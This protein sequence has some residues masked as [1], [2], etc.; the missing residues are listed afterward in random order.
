MKVFISWSGKHSQ[1]IAMTLRD[2]LPSVIQALDP[3]V[4]SA[5]IEKGESWFTSINE[6]LVGSN[7]MGIF[8][9]TAENLQAPWMA[10]EAGALAVHDRARV[11]TFL[12]GV[13]PDAI[14]PP[15]GLFQA[16]NSADKTDVFK[17]LESL[18]VRLNQPLS[19]VRLKKAFDSNWDA[20][21][22]DLSQIQD[23]SSKKTAQPDQ[24]V[25]LH[26]ILA[27]VRRIEK[28][29]NWRLG[30]DDQQSSSDGGFPKGPIG[31]RSPDPFGLHAN[32]FTSTSLRNSFGETDATVERAMEILR[33]KDQ[34]QL[35]A[36][37]RLL[38]TS[39]REQKQIDALTDALE[40]NS[41]HSAKSAAERFQMIKR[42]QAARQKGE[43]QL[44][45]K[46]KKPS[47]GKGNKA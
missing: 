22:K 35:N 13:G 27:A 4:S 40:A 36:L 39:P 21:E 6:S 9:L 30:G 20:F 31:P 44:A 10:F 33:S 8:C 26:E 25:L 28:D 42:A 18:N 46:S 2:W 23:T 24:Q 1:Q 5:D 12:H 17:L 29:A 34:L 41:V 37:N 47:S 11:A 14:K 38:A 43:G 32:Q 16:T 15:L 19:E 45:E 7:G 3:W